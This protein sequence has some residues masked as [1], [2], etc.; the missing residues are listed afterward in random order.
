MSLKEQFEEAV[1]VSQSLPTRPGNETLLN[2]YSLYKQATFGDCSAEF[3]GNVFDIIGKAKYN[4]W[5]KHNGMT[6]D[7]AMKKYIAIV[8]ELKG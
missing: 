6:S 2:L 4:A 5:K 1:A 7:D 8:A 3:T